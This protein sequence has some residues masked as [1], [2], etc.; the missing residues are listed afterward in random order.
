VGVSTH[1]M[2]VGLEASISGSSQGKMEASNRIK[3]SFRCARMIWF[4]GSMLNVVNI[5]SLGRMPHY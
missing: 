2:T 1:L 4:L 5:D 3:F